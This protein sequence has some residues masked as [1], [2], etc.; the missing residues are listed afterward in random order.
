M[1]MELFTDRVKSALQ[2]ARETAVRWGN[3][4]VGT[5][6]LLVGIIAEGGGIAVEA[7]RNLGVSLPKLTEDLEK[8]SRAA[9]GMTVQESVLAMTPRAKKI[10]EMATHEAR[11]MKHHYVGTEHILLALMQDNK[12][13]LI[14]MFTNHKLT[15]DLVKEE[16]LKVLGG[17]TKE[18]GSVGILSGDKLH[19]PCGAVYKLSVEVL[20]EKPGTKPDSI[21][22]LLGDVKIYCAGEKEEAARM[23]MKRIDAFLSKGDQK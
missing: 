5:E 11:L 12:D 10:L 23:L 20:Q 16:I 15:Y 17:E 22:R 7:L 2:L 21:E 9:G 3:D 6:H 18:A 1:G 13:S 19:C 4:Y 8:D 14:L